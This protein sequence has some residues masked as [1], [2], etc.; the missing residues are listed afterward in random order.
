MQGTRAL[1][2]SVDG[3]EETGINLNKRINKMAETNTY[4]EEDFSS[5]LAAALEEM[6]KKFRSGECVVVQA[7]ISDIVGAPTT[8]LE[9]EYID[10]N[11]T[12]LS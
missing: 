6:A 1:P 9:V 2:T 7:S 3:R 5:G 12:R 8:L 10:K 11:S 4:Q